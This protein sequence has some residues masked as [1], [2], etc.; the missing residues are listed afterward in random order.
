MSA[1]QKQ[2]TTSSAEE[3]DSNGRGSPDAPRSPEASLRAAAIL[4]VL[5]GLRT[6]TEAAEALGVSIN[7]YYLLE[8]K[9]LAGLTAA[10]ELQPKGPKG[11]GAEARLKSLQRELEQ[12]QR[13]CLR[14]A[15]LVR[16]TQRAVGLSAVSAAAAKKSGKSGKSALR[17]KRKRRPQVRALRAAEEARKNC[18][19]PETDSSL[20]GSLSDSRQAMESA[21]SPQVKESTD[22]AQ[23]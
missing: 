10:C 23:G 7:H 8:R 6:A 5:A 11:P 13:E 12:C 15:A 14:Q 16:A 19:G 22:G 21:T 18:S 1:A 4:E 2:A 3:R 9:A 17:K 20:S